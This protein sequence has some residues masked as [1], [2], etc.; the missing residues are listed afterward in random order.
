[1]KRL[2]MLSVL[3]LAGCF[4]Q[5]EMVREKPKPVEDVIHVIK[6]V[7]TQKADYEE[8]VIRPNK[9][10]NGLYEVWCSHCKEKVADVGKNACGFWWTCRKSDLLHHLPEPKNKDCTL[11]VCPEC[12]EVCCVATR[13]H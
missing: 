8:D 7:E 2:T 1:M 10:N 11:G 5:P 6:T 9:T 13:K 4:T 3:F 12:G